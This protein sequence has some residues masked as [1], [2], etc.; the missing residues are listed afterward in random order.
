VRVAEC[1]LQGMLR[2]II[3]IDL[4]GL[5]EQDAERALLDG[6]KPSGKPTQ[7]ARFPGQRVAL[8]VSTAPFPPELGRLYG[9]PELPPHYLPREAHL[10][11]L[12]QKLLDG[13]AN[14]G[15]T[16]QSAAVGVQGMGGIGK[17]VLATALAHDPEVRKAF[18]EGI[19]WLTVGQAPKSEAQGGEA[20]LLGLQGQLMSQLTGAQPPAFVRVQQGKDALREA[21]VGRRALVILD[22]VW[23]IED[24][25][26]FWIDAQPARL[27]ITTRNDEVLVGLGAEQHRVDVLSPDDALK[28]LADW[29]GE[30]SPDKQFASI[31]TASHSP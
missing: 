26:A 31:L 2:P 4:I 15:I 20:H 30:K 27:L 24:A 21:L 22:D 23:T 19:F 13:G 14:V 16:G 25:D 5:D 7:P 12:K 3:Y 18:P 10:G 1:T 11:G 29:A 8:G 17:T 9:V 6:L 28:M